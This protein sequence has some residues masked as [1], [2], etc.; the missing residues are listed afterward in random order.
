MD[1]RLDAALQRA[2]FSILLAQKKN[3]MKARYENAIM[4]GHNG[5]IF[6]ISPELISFIQIFIDKKYDEAVLIDTK[7]YPIL[8]EDLKVFLNTLMSRYFEASNLYH[9]EYS[10]L[11]KARTVE[12]LS[13]L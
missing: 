2:N 1:P 11:R 6:K 10:A 4:Y 9:A 12:A 7:G 5:G 8:V 3:E 13:K